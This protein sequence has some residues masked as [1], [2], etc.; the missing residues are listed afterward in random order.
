MDQITSNIVMIRPANFGFN[1]ETAANNSF[2]KNDK[3]LSNDEIKNLAIKEFDGLVAKLRENGINVLVFE[4]TDEPKKPDAVFPNNWISFHQEGMVMK[5]PMFAKARRVERRQDIIEEIKNTYNVTK[6][7]T[8]EHYEEEDMY[9]E[10]TGSL[11]LDRENK[12]VYANLSPRTD[13][14]LL[15]KWCILM[16]Y[17]KRKFYAKDRKGEDI[18]HTNVIMA[19]GETFCVICMD[20]IPEGQDK[21]MLSKS[22]YSTDKEIINI[23]LDQVEAFAGNMLQLKNK[24]GKRYLVMSQTAYD[25]LTP[26]QLEIINKHTFIITAAIPT[27]EKYGGGSVR[28][29]MAELFLTQK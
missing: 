20:C 25:C 15:D 11:I 19:L 12:L 17:E 22:L 2:Q 14:R 28:C 7:Y 13:L 27:I 16:G 18:Y 6:E 29:M 1:V 24:A 23:T 10:G 8:F 21:A 3:S 4:D 9:L 5:Y 26:Q